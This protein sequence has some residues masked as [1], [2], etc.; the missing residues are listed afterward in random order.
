LEKELLPLRAQEK[1]LLVNYGPDHP[2]VLAVRDRIRMT[3][4]VWE[5]NRQADGLPFVSPARS[6][7]APREAVDGFLDALRRE[8]EG[9]VVSEA[10]LREL[11]HRQVVE[12]RELSLLAS[13]DDDMLK[14]ISSKENMAETIRNHL[15]EVGVVRVLGGYDA[16]V[17]AA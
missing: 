14:D 15:T 12:A 13:K 5:Q 6:G 11:L 4:E 9:L 3:R 17:L 1:Q 8:R 16:Q 10:T 2:D 7:P